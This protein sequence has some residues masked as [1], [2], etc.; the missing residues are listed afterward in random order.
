MDRLPTE[1]PST[2]RIPISFLLPSAI[3]MDKPSNPK[4]EI[5]KV[6]KANNPSRLLSLVSLSYCLIRLS[7]KTENSKG[8]LGL[9]SFHFEDHGDTFAYEQDIYLEKK[10]TVNGDKKSMTIKQEV[11]GLF[12]P[13]YETYDLKLIGMP[14][15]PS[16]IIIDGR[17]F[18]GNLIFDDLKRGRIK[19]TK[20]FKNIQLFK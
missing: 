5:S 16:K 19:V 7:S 20:H 3:K 2:F 10:F 11:E 4:L 13:R 18:S 6:N 14:F 1:A 8:I 12:T 9:N 15:K 17:D